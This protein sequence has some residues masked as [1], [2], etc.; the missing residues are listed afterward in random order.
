MA[1]VIDRRDEELWRARVDL[2]AAFRWTARLSMHEGV[3]NH[4]SFA[5]SDDGS[6]FLMNPDCRHFSR[7]RA[8]E[9]LLLDFEAGD[10]LSGVHG[11]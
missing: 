7:I 2:A 1:A 4:Y 3:A 6:E 10:R 5:V 9:L 8:S 11:L